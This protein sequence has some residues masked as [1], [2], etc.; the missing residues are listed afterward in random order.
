MAL[1]A[2]KMNEDAGARHHETSSAGDLLSPVF[3]SHPNRVFSGA[4]SPVFAEMR[5]SWSFLTQSSR[6]MKLWLSHGDAAISA[7][8]VYVHLRAR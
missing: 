2:T 4:N 7:D 5:R 1:R 3:F 6:T 8:R